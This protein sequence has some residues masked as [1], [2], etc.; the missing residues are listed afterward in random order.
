MNSR[1]SFQAQAG[2]AQMGA[3]NTTASTIIAP[4]GNQAITFLFDTSEF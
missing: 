2:L 3:W 4:C 1:F